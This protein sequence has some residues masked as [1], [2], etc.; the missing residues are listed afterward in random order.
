MQTGEEALCRCAKQW[1]LRAEEGKLESHRKVWSQL[2]DIVRAEEEI[3]AAGKRAARLDICVYIATPCALLF[4]IL[5]YANGFERLALMQ[6]VV[7]PALAILYV[8]NQSSKLRR[9]APTLLMLIGVFVF[10]CLIVEGGIEGSGIN[11]ACI[12]PFIAF[13]A[14]GL[15]GGLIWTLIYFFSLWGMGLGESAQLWTIPFT[16]AE[17][18]ASLFT[19]LFFAIVASLFAVEQ[20][21]SST[22]LFRAKSELETEIEVRKQAED[23]RA[24][25]EEHMLHS[26]KLNSLGL[27][28]SG[29]AHD[30]N[31]ILSVVSGFAELTLWDTPEKSPLRTN[32]SQIL[33]ASNQAAKLCEQLLDYAGKRKPEV[34][35]IDLEQYIQNLKPMLKSYSGG[36]HIELMFQDG[37]PPVLVDASQLQQALVNLVMN[38]LESMDKRDGNIVIST[39]IVDVDRKLLDQSY[40]DHEIPVGTYACIEV[41]DNGRGIAEDVITKI[42]DPFFS[43]KAN[44]H[45][46]GMA[47]VLGFVRTHRGAIF[48]DSRVGAGSTFQVLLP[49]SDQY[50]EVIDTASVSSVDWHASG[51]V[52]VADADLMVRQVTCRMLHRIGFE[53]IEA[54]D[55]IEAMGMFKQHGKHIDL[56]IVDFALPRMNGVEVCQGIRKQYS[57]IPILLLSGF[58][59]E[60][61]RDELEQAEASGFLHK[62][63]SHDSLRIKIKM[64]LEQGKAVGS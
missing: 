59:E 37:I 34:T 9:L 63:F 47:V 7:I 33:D 12:F 1:Q 48:V 24:L 27:M 11:Y 19:Y 58:A 44:G 51:R 5:N 16:Q 32:L 4:G 30:F 38:A 25:A 22:R 29:I 64:L 55:G 8:V 17:L 31:N 46:L 49:I 15:R 36:Q 62:P 57:E 56:A 54:R 42:F 13:Y 60:D 18:N 26:E 39:R 2:M 41:R 6:W 10:S 23:A 61:L 20:A 45:G 43:T 21:S 14:M 35:L 40:A 50:V 3:M 28:A 53:T 52:L